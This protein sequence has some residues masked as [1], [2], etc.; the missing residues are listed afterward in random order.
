[1]SNLSLKLEEKRNLADSGVLYQVNFI[2]EH[3]PLEENYLLVREGL[4]KKREPFLRLPPMNVSNISIEEVPV[5]GFEYDNNLTEKNLFFRIGFPINPRTKVLTEFLNGFQVF[6]EE[7]DWY[8][9]LLQGSKATSNPETELV[10]RFKMTEHTEVY[11]KFDKETIGPV[12]LE[13]KPQ[14]LVLPEGSDGSKVTIVL[15]RLYD[16]ISKEWYWNI[17]QL[18]IYY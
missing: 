5:P 16:I 9:Y 7:G 1:M 2:D 18:I 10:T 11:Q 4:N 17:Y 8:P 6:C 12:K 13:E 3:Y 14:E 15:C